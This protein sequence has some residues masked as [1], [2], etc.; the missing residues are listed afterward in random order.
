MVF[1]KRD[2]QISLPARFMRTYGYISK[3]L[4]PYKVDTVIV[5]VTAAGIVARIAVAGRVAH[6]DGVG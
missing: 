1:V 6:M 2:H 5:L 3:T 4:R